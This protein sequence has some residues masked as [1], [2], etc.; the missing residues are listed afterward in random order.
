ML[1]LASRQNRN[2]ANLLVLITRQG[3]YRSSQHLSGLLAIEKARNPWVV[4]RKTATHECVST[5]LLHLF[6]CSAAS[7]RRLQALKMDR[8][9][10]KRMPQQRATSNPVPSTPIFLMIRHCLSTK[11]VTATSRHTKRYV[12]GHARWREYRYGE[13]N[14]GDERESCCVLCRLTC[15]GERSIPRGTF[16]P[17]HLVLS[18]S[19]KPG[20]LLY[21][22]TK[23]PRSSR[24]TS[25][26]SHQFPSASFVPVSRAA[27]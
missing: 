14:P 18:V 23:K 11:R 27:K 9:A 7:F 19:A 25:K 21:A 26:T 22:N 16:L 3:S 13:G 10:L 8:K 15:Y 2:S 6:C 5:L 17:N 20:R 1:A 24:S 12:S 4:S